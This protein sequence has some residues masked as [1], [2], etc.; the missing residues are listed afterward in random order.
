[1]VER[2]AVVDDLALAQAPAEAAERLPERVQPDVAHDRGLGQPRRAARVDVGGLVAERLLARLG[3]V[4]VGSR[5]Q[6][7]AP[8]GQL[9]FHLPL[10][11]DVAV[12]QDAG[13]QLTAHVLERHRVLRADDDQLRFAHAQRVQQRL[14]GVVAV[15]QRGDRADLAGREEVPEVRRPIVEQERDHV[16]LADAQRLVRVGVAIDDRVGLRVRVALVAVEQEW[17]A[18]D[19][20]ARVTLELQG[21]GLV[22]ARVGEQHALPRAINMGDPLQHRARG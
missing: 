11:I 17:L 13:V 1:V 4:R 2:Q 12:Q 20:R 16:A 10:W 9:A 15:D 21:D 6:A 14:P 19:R 22:A 18:A 7:F 5:C 3:R 8:D